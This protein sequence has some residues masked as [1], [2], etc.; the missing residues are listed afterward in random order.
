MRSKRTHYET[1]GVDQYAP[2]AEIKSQYRRLVKRYHPDLNPGHV[3]LFREVQAAYDV[4]SDPQKREQYDQAIQPRNYAPPTG[5]GPRSYRRYD[6]RPRYR[7]RPANNRP[8]SIPDRPRSAYSHYTVDVT[9]P[10]L[11]HGAR[12]HLTVGQTFTCGRCRGTGRLAQFS[13]TCER[14]GGFGF[15]VTY[16][17]VEIIIPPGLM[18]DMS[19][20]ISVEEG[21]PEHPLL[22][23][24]IMTNISVTIRL[25]ESPPFTYQNSQLYTS[26]Q[27]PAEVL[28]DGGDWTI[29]AP[30]GGQITFKIPANTLSGSTLTLRKRGLRNGTS[31]RRGNLL[32]TVVAQDSRQK[33]A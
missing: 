31:Q 11:F 28:T 1:L 27:V 19:I 22:S 5:T 8:S 12:R 23:A 29:P 25:R 2:A 20:R 9:L 13:R 16:K 7:P 15:L 17:V 18:P 3:H 24:P 32:C 33:S 6:A 30:E 21:Q 10:E 4:L 26:A 14:C